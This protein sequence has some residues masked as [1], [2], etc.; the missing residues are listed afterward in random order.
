MASLVQRN[1]DKS[2]KIDVDQEKT[3]GW[4]AQS[5]NERCV[6]YTRIGAR[7]CLQPFTLF[8]KIVGFKEL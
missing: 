4:N 5:W 1:E 3:N 8:C 7:F 2:I 6:Y